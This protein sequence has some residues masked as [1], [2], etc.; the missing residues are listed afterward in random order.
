[1][2]MKDYDDNPEGFVEQILF[3][4]KGNHEDVV[5]LMTAVL[6]VRRWRKPKE[7]VAW[8]DVAPEGQNERGYNARV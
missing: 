2:Q 6:P 1:M 4:N 8:P 5:G 7:L 3:C